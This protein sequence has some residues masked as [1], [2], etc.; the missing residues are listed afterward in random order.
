MNKKNI[1]LNTKKFRDFLSSKRATQSAP[2]EKYVAKS[3]P[4]QTKPSANK[5][6]SISF[7]SSYTSYSV[8][9]QTFFAKRL[10]FLIKSG[11]P[12]LESIHVL[13][14]QSTNRTEAFILE[15]IINDIANGQT[16][17]N[18]L[19]KFRNVFGNFAI[20][21]IR[22]GEASGTLIHNLNYLAEE[23]KKRHILRKKI[24]SALLYPAIIT[25]A[26]FGITGFLT[27]YIFPKIMP[28]FAS[29]SVK[30]P[31]TTRAIIWLSDLL[32][33]KGWLILII[34]AAIVAG[35]IIIK[36][37]SPKVRFFFDGFI[38]RLPIFGTIAKNYN[39]TNTTRTMGILLK[40]SMSLTEALLVTAETT[41]NV[42]YKAA[43]RK[44]S[45]EVM[46][47]KNLSLPIMKYP[48]LFPSMLSHLV[49]IGEKSGNL[50]N[51]FTYLSEYYE[52]EFEEQ[53]KNLSSTIEPVLMIIMGIMVGFVA[54]S[55]IT[56]IYELTGN[57][58][59]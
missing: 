33:T 57:V 15:K 13:K 17:S 58:S 2:K 41:E 40:S 38:L 22:A 52:H 31:F 59:R 53:T 50:S 4:G 27:V 44:M 29:M 7:L 47:G 16:L 11:V 14:D 35:F 25:I 46:K 56:P 45:E 32:R 48:F 43:L 39:L 36:K 51:T 42:Q 34:I 3:A 30:L 19:A 18:S 12:M 37:F 23:L 1:K 28:I 5:N 55:I 49:A 9:K 21:V 54:V 26:T 6:L 24:K 8:K 20:N 10:S